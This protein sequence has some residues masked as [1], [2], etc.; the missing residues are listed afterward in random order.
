M[1]LNTPSGCSTIKKKW[2]KSLVLLKQKNNSLKLSTNL[3]K[4]GE[5]V[6][7]EKISTN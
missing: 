6:I 5:N 2:K 1:M 7:N 3:R 4:I